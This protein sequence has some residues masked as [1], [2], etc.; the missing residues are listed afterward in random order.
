LNQIKSLNST[1]VNTLK[2]TWFSDIQIF[3]VFLLFWFQKQLYFFEPQMT[4]DFRF[5][6]G[7][8][9]FNIWVITSSVKLFFMDS[10]E[11]PWNIQFW[12]YS[13]CTFTSIKTNYH[14]AFEDLKQYQQITKDWLGCCLWFE[15]ILEAPQSNFDD[16][17]FGCFLSAKKNIFLLKESTRNSV[18]HYV[19][20]GSSR[21]FWEEEISKQKQILA[22]NNRSFL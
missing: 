11:Y 6:I 10:N 22:F 7:Q 8:K 1:P 17:V 18:S 12:L 13:S 19:W 2:K 9:T 4:I 5:K 14:N 15:K 21:R 16:W 20:W 3:R